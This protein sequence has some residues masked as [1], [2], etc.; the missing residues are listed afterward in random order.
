MDQAIKNLP[1][2]RVHGG[3]GAVIKIF[4][5]IEFFS[6]GKRRIADQLERAL[7]RAA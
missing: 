7:L 3:R 1:I 5:D 6:Y 4:D 2:V